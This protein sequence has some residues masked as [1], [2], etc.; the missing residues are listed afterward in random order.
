MKPGQCKHFTG[1]FNHDCCAA[2][3]NYRTLSGGDDFGWLRRLPC[4]G[5]RGGSVAH[6]VVTCAN[7][8]SVTDEEIAQHKADTDAYMARIKLVLPVVKEWRAKQPQG[9]YEVIE[10]PACNGRL[11][12]SQA[13]CNGHVHG[14]CE[15]ENCI[16]WME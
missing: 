14:K 16:H 11:H 2:G 7:H 8:L 6:Q 5:A 9:K 3:V 10:C 12:L 15:T 1:A 13:A 4:T